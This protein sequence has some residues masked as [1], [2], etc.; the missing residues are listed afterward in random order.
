MKGS[1]VR[2]RASALSKPLETAAFW[3]ESAPDERHRDLKIV[4][5]TATDPPLMGR[6]TPPP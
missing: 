2:I 1:A 5:D 6:L 4:D 3:S